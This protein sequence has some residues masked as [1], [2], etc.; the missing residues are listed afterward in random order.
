[1]PHSWRA[2]DET[3]KEKY[4]TA[5]A[6]VARMYKDELAESVRLWERFADADAAG[7]F[8]QQSQRSSA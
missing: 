8:A 6:D 4:V 5:C 2:Q 3:L 1:M 7:R